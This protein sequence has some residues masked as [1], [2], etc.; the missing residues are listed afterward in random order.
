M[1]FAVGAVELAEHL[2]E[3]IFNAVEGK[4]PSTRVVDLATAEGFFVLGEAV[5]GVV[6]V[7]RGGHAPEIEKFGA[8]VLGIN[9]SLDGG[10]RAGGEFLLFA[11]G[12]SVGIIT[13][14]VVVVNEGGGDGLVFILNDIEGGEAGF[15]LVF[16][17]ILILRSEVF[18]GA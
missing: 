7:G 1:G 2:I 15:E 16:E 17:M 13:N 18:F 3:A 10:D 14:A 9:Y 8:I 4:I 12:G 11:A 6:W 5:P